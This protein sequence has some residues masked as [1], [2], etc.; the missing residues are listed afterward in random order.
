LLISFVVDMCELQV[1]RVIP[2]YY[3]QCLSASEMT[4]LCKALCKSTGLRYCT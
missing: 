3:M 2:H 1:K 4:I